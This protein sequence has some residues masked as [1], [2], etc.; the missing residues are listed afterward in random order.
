MYAVS[1]AQ[2]VLTLMAFNL[3]RRG[4]GV[5]AADDDAMICWEGS[6][7]S[8]STWNAPPTVRATGAAAQSYTAFHS[9]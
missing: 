8:P 7:S 3:A 6:N 2:N 4:I 5:H 9:K 1:D